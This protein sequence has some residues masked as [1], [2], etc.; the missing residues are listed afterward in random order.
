MTVRSLGHLIPRIDPSAWVSEAAYVVGDV[1]I[2]PG[3]SVWPGAVIRGDFAPIRI[4][5]RTHV[6]D[7]CVLHT[8]EPMSIGDDVTMGHGVVVHCRSVGSRCLLGNNSTLLDGAVVGDECVIAAGAVLRPGVVVPDGSFAAGV[9]ALVR[10]RSPEERARRR[11]RP[12]EDGDETPRGG[13]AAMLVRY[14]D[15]GL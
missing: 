10:A 2:G 13:Y 15:A 11:R 14:R 1:E 4:G 5:A 12:P 8:G 9:P 7:N 3:S 6:E